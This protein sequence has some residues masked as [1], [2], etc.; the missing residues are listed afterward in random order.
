MRSPFR[1]CLVALMVALAPVG[2]GSSGG[3]GGSAGNGGQSGHAGS[4]GGGAGSGAAGVGGGGGKAEP[5]IVVEYPLPTAHASPQT[6]TK[7][8][9]GLLWFVEG[10]PPQ[11]GAIGS[12]GAVQELAAPGAY[13]FLTTGPD[14]NLWFTLSFI[15]EIGS[16]IP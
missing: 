5:R 2:C 8:P 7:G 11:I 14:G 12:T 10:G 6:I 15:S 13:T 1:G 4:V 3:P 16:V 9:G